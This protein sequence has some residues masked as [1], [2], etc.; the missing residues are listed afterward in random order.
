MNYKALLKIILH[1]FIGG[2]GVALTSIPTG[3]PIT[4]KTILLPAVAS[5]ITSVI[6][7]FALR[8]TKQE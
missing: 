3:V 5:G 2:A 6:S 1:A 7:L 8:P 4:S